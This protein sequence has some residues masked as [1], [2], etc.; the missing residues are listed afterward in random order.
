M[1]QYATA[2]AIVTAA[3]H[4]AGRHLTVLD[5]VGAAIGEAHQSGAV[6]VAR[7]RA[8]CPDVHNRG[9]A[10]I[11]EWC[12]TLVALV[13]DVQRHR[14]SAAVERSLE[15]MLARAHHHRY[16]DVGSQRHL[17]AQIRLRAVVYVRGKRFPF[18]IRADGLRLDRMELG[19][20]GAEL[21]LRQLELA[22]I[23]GLEAEVPPC[24]RIVKCEYRPPVVRHWQFVAAVIIHR[25]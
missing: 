4:D 16:V 22:A 14:M 13:A 1:S 9:P 18:R 10:N 24:L 23:C 17:C 2:V 20:H 19:L 6:Q 11:S 3:A 12:C 21:Q 8:F 25:H 7:H 5:A 15:R